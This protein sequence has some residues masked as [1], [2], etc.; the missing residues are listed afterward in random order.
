M[1]KSIV[2]LKQIFYLN[3]VKQFISSKRHWVFL[4]FQQNNTLGTSHKLYFQEIMISLHVGFHQTF[5]PTLV[6]VKLFYNEVSRLFLL[7]AV[8]QNHGL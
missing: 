4:Y 8:R 2:E 5:P 1:Y 6:C 7:E 3:S